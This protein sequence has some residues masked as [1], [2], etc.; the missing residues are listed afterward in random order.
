MVKL[1][2]CSLLLEGGT[3]STGKIVKRAAA[4]WIWRGAQC[5][6]FLVQFDHLVDISLDASLLKA[7]PQRMPEATEDA[8]SVWIRSRREGGKCF[9]VKFDCLVNVC[10]IVTPFKARQDSTRE[11][12][13]G[14]SAVRM[15]WGAECDHF[16]V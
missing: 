4:G 2:C 8:T 10:W 5:H 7:C 11:L 3:Q 12:A 9:S 14:A 6:N 15:G 1:N 16:C 13:E